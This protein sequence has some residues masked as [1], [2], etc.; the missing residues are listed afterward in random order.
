MAYCQREWINLKCVSY[1]KFFHFH[2]I[3]KILYLISTEIFSTVFCNIY[4]NS[5]ERNLINLDI[6]C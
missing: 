3:I 5:N 6:Y 2:F 1:Q 4:N